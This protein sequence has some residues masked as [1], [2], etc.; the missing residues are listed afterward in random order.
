MYDGLL[1]DHDGVL[2]TID[3]GSTLAESAIAAFGDV[4]VED[5]APDAVDRIDIRA[6]REG[7]REVSDRY[8]V[9]PDRL[10]RARDDRIRDA[11]LARVR[12]GV[13]APYDDVDTLSRVD[14]PV[15]VVSNN[16][17]RIV[18]TVLDRY[19]LSR[20]VDTVRARA[21]R[22]ESLDRKKPRPTFLEDA[23][24]AL[25]VQNPLYVGDSESDVEA[26]HRAGLDTAYIRRDHNVDRS[27]DRDPTYEVEG[28]DDVVGILRQ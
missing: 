3:G 16:Q 15:G 18:D 20:H 21:P 9:D 7:L 8:G 23:M 12:E 11:L 19:G 1:L 5:P 13:K 6:T 26:G 14:G 10:W 22:P 17:A 28:L 24:D 27:L 2:V 25:A 4:G